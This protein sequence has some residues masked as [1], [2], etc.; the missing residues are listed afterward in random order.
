MPNVHEYTHTV[1]YYETDQ[2]AIAHHSNYIRWMEETRVAV[3]DR[4]GCGMKELEE[5]GIVSPVVS[6]QCRY[7]EP[8]KFGDNVKIRAEVSGYN[9]VRLTVRYTMINERTGNVCAEAESEHCFLSP[10]GRPTNLKKIA[11]LFDEAF[12]KL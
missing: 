10:S 4:N 8:T 1:Q 12:R 11:P 9:G 6:V 3:L 7:K 2:M 5:L